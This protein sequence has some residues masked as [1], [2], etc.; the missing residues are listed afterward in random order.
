MLYFSKLKVIFIYILVI[1]L[2]YISISNFLNQNYKLLDNKINL[3]LDLQGGSYLLLEIDSEPIIV[4]KLQSKFSELKKFFKEKNIKFQNIKIVNNQIKFEID[5]KSK[6]QFISFFTDQ[7]N[8]LINTYFNKYKAFEFD[9]EIEDSNVTID[10]SKFGIIEIKNSSIDLALEIVR[11]RVDEI[12]TNEP[13]ILKRGNERILVELP[14][15]DDPSRIKNLL[16]RTANLTFRF[17][18]D[19]NAEGFGSEKMFF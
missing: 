17:I 11:R 10:Y 7:N 2:S 1:F 16:G 18:A 8:N 15:L 13:N 9:Y 5:E 14:G 12:G 3:G 6:N 19:E 4:Q